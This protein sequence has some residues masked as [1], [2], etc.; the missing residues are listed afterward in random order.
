MIQRYVVNTKTFDCLQILH[1]FPLLQFILCMLSIAVR[2]IMSFYSQCEGY[3]RHAL[4]P[5]PTPTPA[6]IFIYTS[7]LRHFFRFQTLSLSLHPQTPAICFPHSTA[8]KVPHDKT[9]VCSS[10]R[11]SNFKTNVIY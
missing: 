5:T 1:C 9:A 4:S 8:G 10:V 2:T 3:L 6:H 7:T 11:T